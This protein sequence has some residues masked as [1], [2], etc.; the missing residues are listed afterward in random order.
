MEQIRQAVERAKAM[1]VA[2]AEQLGRVASSPPRQQITRTASHSDLAAGG[3]EPESARQVDLDLTH[4]E[5]CRIIAHNVS[6]PRSKSFDMLRTQILQSMDQRNWRFLAVT[7]P[8][9]GCG[10]TLTAINLALSI[11]HQPD[12]AALLVDLDLH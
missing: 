8:T 2:T 4:L 3:K 10:K 9:P 11:A 1:E 12:R 5:G 7:S 6:D